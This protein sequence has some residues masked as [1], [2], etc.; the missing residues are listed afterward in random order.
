LQQEL[1]FYFVHIK[2]QFTEAA[3]N[4]YTIIII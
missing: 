1:E 3:I 2:K 4:L